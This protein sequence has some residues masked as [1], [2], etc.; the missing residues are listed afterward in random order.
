MFE[1]A[2]RS[3]GLAPLVG[4][5]ALQLLPLIAFVVPFDTPRARW[6][7]HDGHACLTASVAD[8]TTRR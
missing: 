4:V 3:G 2:K 1:S 8:T 5:I 6:I 7:D